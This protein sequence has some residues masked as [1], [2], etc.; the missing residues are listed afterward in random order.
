MSPEEL[1]QHEPPLELAP[2]RDEDTPPAKHSSRLW[3][4]IAVIAVIAGLITWRI[5]SSHEQAA[6]AAQKAAAA[7]NR[8]T[9]V[10]VADVQQRTMPI[11][12]E[13]LGT[14][15]AYNTVTVKSRVDGQLIKVNFTEGQ[16]VR[17]GQLLLQIDPA[18]TPPPSPRRKASTR[19]MKP[20]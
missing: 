14:V 10:L 11:Y 12:F 17:R 6:A 3:I 8:P 5:V 16:Q 18:P 13:A 7:A 9:P 20:P 19:R 1:H 15:T 2:A 4:I